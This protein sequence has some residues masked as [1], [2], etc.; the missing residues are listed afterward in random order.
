MFRWTRTQGFRWIRRTA[1]VL[2]ALA[3]IAV[4]CQTA[5]AIR[6]IWGTG[7][8]EDHF[9]LTGAA[10]ILNHPA[11]IQLWDHDGEYHGE[12]RGDAKALSAVLIDF[13]KLDAKH[14]R[15]VLHDGIGQSDLEANFVRDPAKRAARAL[16]WMFTFWNARDWKQLPGRDAD[17]CPPPKIDVYTGGNLHWS[18]VTVPEGI[19]VIDERLEAHGFTLADGIVLEGKVIDL[20]TRQPLAARIRL[21]RD[22]RQ[23]KGRFTVVGEAVAD[24]QG[25]WVLKNAPANWVD[26]IVEADGYVPRN[27][28]FWGV[29]DQPGWHFYDCELSRP[30]PVSGGVADEAGKRGSP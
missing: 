16:D 30:A 13:A 7:P 9:G 23:S 26:L 10:A 17:N 14:K 2:L 4:S 11:R 24:A 28:G 27:I 8:V 22:E 21:E 12:Y 20:A 15:V 1:T 5:F 29:D 6:G 19:E 18:D 25:R 3:T